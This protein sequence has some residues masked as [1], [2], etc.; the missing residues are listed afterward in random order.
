MRQLAAAGQLRPEDMVLREGQ[1]RWVQAASVRGL[2]PAAAP[3]APA[4][5]A[6]RAPAPAAPRRRGLA[7]LLVGVA[8]AMVLGVGACG[9]LYVALRLLPSAV[10]TSPLAAGSGKGNVVAAGKPGTPSQGGGKEGGAAAEQPDRR[11]KQAL[12]LRFIP[13]EASAAVVVHPRR[14]LQSPLAAALPPVPVL[15]PAAGNDMINGLGVSPEQVEQVI[16]FLQA[17][18]ARPPT[19][20]PAP[21]EAPPPPADGWAELNS[22]EGRFTLRFPVKPKSSERRTPLGMRQVFSAEADD[23]NLTFEISYVDFPFDSPFIGDEARVDFATRGLEFRPGFKEKKDIKLGK[24]LGAEVVLDDVQLRTYSVHRVYVAGNRLYELEAA[25]HK[26]RKLPPEFARFF[27]SFRVTGAGPASPA[28][29]LP[30][31]LTPSGGAIVRFTD[32]VDGK[33]L[34]GKLLK[35]MREAKQD[36]KVY[37]VG[38]AEEGPLGQSMAGYVADGRTLLL[39][40]EPVLRKML[41][42]AGASSPLLDRLRRADAGDDLTAVLS[43][44]PYRKLMNTLGKPNQALLPP[45]LA[46][47]ATLPDHLV[48]VTATVNLGGKQLARLTLEADSEESAR[49]AEKVVQG[50]LDQARQA[51]RDLR[52]MVAAQLPPPSAPSLLPVADQLYGGVHV[53][54]AGTRV[55]VTLDRQPVP[56][57]PEGLIAAAGFNDAEGLNSDPVPDSPYPLGSNNRVGGLGEPGWAGPWSPAGPAVTFQKEVVFEGDGAL[58]LTGEDNIGPGFWRQLAEPQRAVFDVEMH[59][60]VPVG[61]RFT[62]Y[63][64]NGNQPSHEGPVWFVT[65]G[66]FQ[67]ADAGVPPDTGLTCRPGKWYKVSMHV[68]VPKRQWEFAVDDQRFMPPQ[69]LKFRNRDEPQLDTIAFLCRT[70]PG[71]YIDAVRFTRAPGADPGR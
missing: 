13:A 40:P 12:D 33:Q 69:S 6:S 38:P 55:V 10:G 66:K 54:R 61:A 17:G 63:L 26:E 70:G 62:V 27:D 15:P 35:G 3:P 30:P 8:S 52:P 37:Y 23:G 59:V 2:F 4:P 45:P 18:A 50:G 67:V 19:E 16:V 56:K 32:P 43:L 7:C 9:G 34:L 47:A 64:K 42:A 58:Y 51:Y 21:P 20:A 25:T 28:A 36:G 49:T 65:D 48:W 44:E 71:V 29:L 5:V 31:D 60:Q 1:Q 57:L 11:A 22:K 24:Y 53:T 68:D 46:E 14:I 39:A 41:A